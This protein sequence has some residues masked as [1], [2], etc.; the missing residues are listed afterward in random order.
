MGNIRLIY[1]HFHDLRIEQLIQKNKV[2]LK[3]M[4][5][6]GYY[7]MDGWRDIYSVA[8]DALICRIKQIANR[9]REDGDTF[10]LIGVGG[11][12]QGAR[13]AISLLGDKQI[14]IMYA[15]NNFS[16]FTLQDLLSKI[17]NKSVYANVIAKNFKTL[18]PGLTF[19]VLR[20]F[21]NSKYNNK[22]VLRRIIATGTQNSDFLWDISHNAGYVFLPF[23]KN[24]GG[25]Y[26]VFSAVGLLPMAVAGI[27]ICEMLRGANDYCHYIDENKYDNHSIIYATLRN[28]LYEQGKKIE[29][30]VYF[31]PELIYF[32]KWW[33]QLFGE[34]EGKCGK[35]IFPTHL[36]YSEDLHSM[37]QY[38]QEGERMLFETFLDI[39][40]MPFDVAIPKSKVNDGFDYLNEK[41]FNQINHAAFSGTVAAHREAGVPIVEISIPSKNPYYIG[42]LLFF[43]M[44]ACFYSAVLLGVDPFDQPGVEAYKTNMSKILSY[45]V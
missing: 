1:D 19:R 20:E 36:C 25:R 32:A 4:F 38:I 12:N 10:I 26:S 37:G 29:I 18:E 3:T 45:K 7:N 34:S 6:P 30:L 44:Y 21:I 14:E 33:V 11:S 28:I 22:E 43:F 24:I 13:A 5:S 23:P 42:Q 31:I 16:V 9:V 17:E 15:G 39:E 35:G 2:A 8:N 27:D 40:N 41:T